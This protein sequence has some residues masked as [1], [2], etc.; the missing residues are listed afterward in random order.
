VV[1]VCLKVDASRATAGLTSI[2]Y[3]ELIDPSGD[4]VDRCGRN[5]TANW[6]LRAAVGRSSKLRNEQRAFAVTGY[7]SGFAI[8]KSSLSADELQ[9]ERIT[10][11]VEST[12]SVNG[13]MTASSDATRLKDLRRNFL[14]CRRT[15]VVGPHARTTSS[16]TTGAQ[17]GE[18]RE[19]DGPS[20]RH[21][22]LG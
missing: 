5:L 8:A 13:A 2:G 21:I 15:R 7:D 16:V 9:L 22:P 3:F 20:N 4:A 14:Q 18:V 1:G 6:H 12:R 17:R 10:F 11:E 19:R